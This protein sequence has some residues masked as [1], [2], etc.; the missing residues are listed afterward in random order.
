MWKVRLPLIALPVLVGLRRLAGE[1]GPMIAA[2]QDSKFW[3]CEVMIAF[4]LSIVTGLLQLPFS[5][6]WWF[7]LIAAFTLETQLLVGVATV[8]SLTVLLGWYGLV[9][10]HP[11]AI[12]ALW[13]C[14][15]GQA[16][17]KDIVTTKTI[18]AWQV[19]DLSV[20]AL[21][22]I[23]ILIWHG[24][25]TVTASSVVVALPMNLIWLWGMTL[26]HGR[27]FWKA[28]LSDTNYVYKITPVLPDSVWSWIYGS[29]WAACSLWLILLLLPT[30]V[31]SYAAVLP[32]CFA[33]PLFVKSQFRED[34]LC[35]RAMFFLLAHV[36]AV[37][38]VYR[39]V[40]HTSSLRLLLE[41]LIMWQMSALGITCGSHRL[42][43]HRS[44]VAETPFR[45]LLMLLT[46]FANQ[47][48]IYHWSRDHRAHHKWTDT[49]GD[50][51]DTTRGF[52]YA[53]IGWLLVPKTPE[54][55]TRGKTIPCG[56]LLADPVVAFQQ[57]A[58]DKFMFMQL[59][60]FGLPSVYG[61]VV[62]GDAGLGFLVHG[63]LRWLI[64]LH[65]TWCVNSVAHF[66][67]DTAYDKK[68]SARET[69]LASVVAVGEGWHSYHHKYPWDYAASEFGVHR[70]WNPS[71][72]LIDF[73]V[74][75]GQAHHLK[76]ADHLARK[77]RC[78]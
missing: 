74:L 17:D 65:G 66:F 8:L 33:V 77:A 53:H 32:I 49:P 23:L 43:S 70:Q 37:F 54:L 4:A 46:S 13:R 7:L 50:P 55:R 40:Y 27:R 18:R 72:L 68:A 21:P 15:T 45:V 59:M 38:G 12:C 47:G 56:D 39:A 24:A 35:G 19:W 26:G 42:W 67:G 51:H 71:K 31:S 9:L 63:I 28:S 11:H 34:L 60:S 14:K 3:I 78:D 30:S 22:A 2:T 61:Y 36:F 41:V 10:R 48:T 69:L 25:N 58:E 57:F 1:V 76:R 75:I 73:A 29:Q 62:Y 16:L 64:T 44:Y 20:H 5:V 52:F 6:T